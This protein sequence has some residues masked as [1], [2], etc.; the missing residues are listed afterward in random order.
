MPEPVSKVRLFLVDDE[1]QVRRGV[2][3]LLGARAGLELC[4]SAESVAAAL[5]LIP[6]REPDL[7]LVDL[8]LK[9][10]DGFELIRRLRQLRPR[11]KL[12]VFSMHN[13]PFH[14]LQA[15]EAGAHGYVPKD[16]GPERL[17]EA[18]DT[19]LAG[20]CYISPALAARLPLLRRRLQTGRH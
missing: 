10:D 9:G 17:L 11:L 19:L 2:E 7:V 15:F 8:A 13:E 3:I 14:V 12:L 16:E 5:Q 20:R 1:P 4:G 18:I 6:Q